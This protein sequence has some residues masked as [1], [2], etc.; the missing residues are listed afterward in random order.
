MNKKSL[1]KFT[2]YFKDSTFININTPINKEILDPHWI[3]GFI[4][5]EGCFYIK[6][7]KSKSKF[8]SDNYSLVFTISQHSRDLLLLN[9]IID[10]L[11]CGVIEI[12]KGRYEVIYIVYNFNDHLNKVIPFFVK[13]SLITVKG[14]DFLDYKMVGNVLIKKNLLTE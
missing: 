13:H 2:N 1:G 3:V 6:P 11:Q 10:Y 9:N 4:D 5:A 14:L 12:P 8:K 7:I